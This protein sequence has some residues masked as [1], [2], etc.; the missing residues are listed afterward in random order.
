MMKQPRDLV[1][2]SLTKPP[3]VAAARG[4]PNRY[5]KITSHNMEVDAQAAREAAVMAL[6]G[7]RIRVT[8]S[9]QRTVFGLLHCIDSNLNIIVKDGEILLP[10]G[11]H[12][13]RM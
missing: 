3:A 6:M 5:H 2:N 10:T 8:L 11:T 9:D 1:Q 4:A 13:P 7:K 12:M